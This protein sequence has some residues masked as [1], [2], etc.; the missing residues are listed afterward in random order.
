MIVLPLVAREF[1][2]LELFAARKSDLA[3]AR[4][5]VICASLNRSVLDVAVTPD[6]ARIM[7]KFS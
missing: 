6:G 7:G 2:S 4:D 1:P 3:S 5:W